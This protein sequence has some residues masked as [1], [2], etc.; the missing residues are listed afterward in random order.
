MET[1]TGFIDHIIFHN[2]ENGYTVFE[3]QS[4]G[5][6]DEEDEMVCVGNFFGISQGDHMRLTGEYKEHKSYGMQFAV[7]T[8]EVIM[9]QDAESI[10]KYLGSGAIK[11]IGPTLAKRIVKEFGDETF[12]I[13]E[14]EPERLGEIKGISKRMAMEFSDQILERRDQRGAMMLLSSF[15]IGGVLSARIVKQYGRELPEI[16]RKNPYQLA[17]EVDGVG[18]ETAD[19]IARQSGMP[20]DSDFRIICGIQ[21]VL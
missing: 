11:G 2:D 4:D 6:N 10:L 12:R 18:F 5:E 8:Y 20:L 14:K 16:L 19:R 9:P 13:M 3:L 15:G 17:E 1:L 21:Y 7:R